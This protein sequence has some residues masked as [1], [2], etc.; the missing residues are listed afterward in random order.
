LPGAWA[1]SHSR[2]VSDASRL[3]RR[4]GAQPLA[5]GVGRI[6]RRYD[7]RV[8]VRAGASHPLAERFQVGAL[9]PERAVPGQPEIACVAPGQVGPGLIQQRR[10]GPDPLGQLGGVRVRQRVLVGPEVDPA[11]DHRALV[12]RHVALGRVDRHVERRIPCPRLSHPV[13]EVE[14]V[15]LGADQVPVD[16]LLHRPPGGA[17]SV[18]P[19]H[20]RRERGVLGSHGLG[21]VVRNTVRERRSFEL[22]PLLEQLNELLVSPALRGRGI[23]A[24][25]QDRGQAECNGQG[26]RAW[27]I[28]T[29]VHG[30]SPV[31]G[32]GGRG[33]PRR[34]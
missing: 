3:A 17:Q 23:A 33:E 5:E 20:P 1:L 18:Q 11:V 25:G 15:H 14:P 31:W 34:G 7:G 13:V 6:P 30:P 9:E 10:N 29:R 26:D 27:P 24:T 2:K 19:V 28:E 16:L 32:V 4:L 21:R 12:G 22:A 8:Q